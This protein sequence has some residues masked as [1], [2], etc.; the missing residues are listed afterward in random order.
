M[1][2]DRARALAELT[3]DSNRDHPIGRIPV[4]ANANHTVRRHG[5]ER[6]RSDAT[7]ADAGLQGIRVMRGA[8]ILGIGG[9]VS[10]IEL[11]DPRPVA[12]D[13]VL[14]AVR[15][16]GVANWDEIVR[17]GGH[18]AVFLFQGRLG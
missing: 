15:A 7:A 6:R 2:R 5:R 12:D 17:Q 4:P 18:S 14:I 9:P 13:E 10:E 8:G 16:A 11:P 1:P 3:R